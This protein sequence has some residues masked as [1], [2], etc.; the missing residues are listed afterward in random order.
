MTPVPDEVLLD[1]EEQFAGVT[2]QHCV[3][4]AL[5]ELR[6]EER[7]ECEECEAIT[8]A[9][10]PPSDSPQPPAT[11]LVQP[12]SPQRSV[13]QNVA[14][15]LDGIA[16]RQAHAGNR[17]EPVVL[18]CERLAEEWHFDEKSHAAKVGDLR[19]QCKDSKEREA[20]A[21]ERAQQ[22]VLDAEERVKAVLKATEEEEVQRARK[23]AQLRAELVDVQDAAEQ[24]REDGDLQVA[25]VEREIGAE[26]RHRDRLEGELRDEPKQAAAARRFEEEVQDREREQM[27][28]RDRQIR[29]H[30]AEVQREVMRAQREAG[31][32]VRRIEL[33]FHQ[34]LAELQRQL[35][36]V[37]KRTRSCVSEE[38]GHRRTEQVVADTEV[39]G[40]DCQIKQHL[41]S[42][43]VQALE[44]QD[45]AV[46]Q[47]K[48]SQARD[49]ALEAL[50]HEQTNAAMSSLDCAADEKHKA[51]L[52]EHEHRH[53]SVAAAKALGDTF[54]RSTQYQMHL[55]A[56]TRSALAASAYAVVAG[57]RGTGAEAGTAA[58]WQQSTRMLPGDE[59]HG[60]A[61]VF[62]A[63]RG[64]LSH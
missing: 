6:A 3:G 40:V 50:L 11:P 54:P 2:T 59:G 58:S 27:Q 17:E 64:L 61:D 41:D 23:L 49:F 37:L 30:R 21:R 39:R 57:G 44:M 32:R 25:G 16:A 13:V 46:R 12:G 48:E 18:R 31:E 22:R 29:D 45:E 10:S 43:H 1:S 53:R 55:S 14:V 8:V 15:Q 63:P 34:D 4:A 62:E 26:R 38:V 52:L 35:D 7:E 5:S 20:K 56:K 28:E 42:T 36:E 33:Q 24:L 19:S 47:V 51:V 9:S 60:Y